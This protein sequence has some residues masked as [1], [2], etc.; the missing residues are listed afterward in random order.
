MDVPRVGR[1][2]DGAEAYDEEPDE[3]SREQRHADG[4]RTDD[5]VTLHDAATWRTRPGV[6]L[7]A[8]SD[9]GVGRELRAE[10]GTLLTDLACDGVVIDGAQHAA[11]Q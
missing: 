9:I 6:L 1:F 4:D 2:Y 10:T 3:R 11:D 7:T 5:G 8:T